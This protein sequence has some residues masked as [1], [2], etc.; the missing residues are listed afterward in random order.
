MRVSTG[1]QDGLLDWNI[2]RTAEFVV[3]CAVGSEE[4]LLQRDR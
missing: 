4:H 2:Q 1:G 3:E